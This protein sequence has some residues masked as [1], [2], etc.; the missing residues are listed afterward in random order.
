MMNEQKKV[1][2]SA[3][4]FGV[5]FIQKGF[6]YIVLRYLN[7]HRNLRLHLSTVKTYHYKTYSQNIVSTLN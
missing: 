1:Q 6:L 7:V 4:A 2:K 3:T 5:T